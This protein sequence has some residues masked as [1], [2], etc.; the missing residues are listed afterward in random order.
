MTIVSKYFFC[1]LVLVACFGSACDRPVNVFTVQQDKDLGAQ[2]AQEIAS[3]PT[4]YP[5]LDEAQYPLVYTYMRAMRDEI[6]NSPEVKFKDEFTWELKI[7]QDDNTLNAFAAPGGYIY[8]YT[9]LI[10]YL[11]KVDH[12]AGV[13]AHEIAH[14]DQRHSTSQ[15]TK[16]YGLEMLVAIASRNATAAQLGQV[17][18]GLTQLGFSRADETDAD[19]HSVDYLE[20][21]KYACNGAAG[22][23]EKL[24]AQGQ[25]GGTPAFL[26]THPNPDNRVDKINEGAD[27]AG[28]SKGPAN[29]YHDNGDNGAYDAMR[30]TLP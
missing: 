22:F 18:S 2:L 29:Y 27:D 10:K 24:I 26:S 1:L 13:L 17:A 3:N 8:I 15:M 20:S 25:S 21:S 30:N 23:F 9:G 11:D 12:L 16:Q 7:I 28:C 14:A 4:E 6:L 19:A 5:L